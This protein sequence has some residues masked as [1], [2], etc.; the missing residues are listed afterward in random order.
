MYFVKTQA[1]STSDPTNK[2]D[3][4]LVIGDTIIAPDL[5]SAVNDTGQ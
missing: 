4:K 5:V 2:F 3:T 1:A